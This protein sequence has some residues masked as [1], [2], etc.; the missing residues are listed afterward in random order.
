[1]SVV[2]CQLSAHYRM[3]LASV[4][5]HGDFVGTRSQEASETAKICQANKDFAARLSTR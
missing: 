3:V 4:T 2:S 5:A 1:M